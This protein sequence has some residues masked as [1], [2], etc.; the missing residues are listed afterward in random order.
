M[1][2]LINLKLS[3]AFRRRRRRRHPNRV[4]IL[5]VV[6]VLSR[7]FRRPHPRCREENTPVSTPS[8]GDTET[9][10]RFDGAAAA[11]DPSTL[12]TSN[13]SS[14]SFSSALTAFTS[15]IELYNFSLADIDI[16]LRIFQHL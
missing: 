1:L 9:F 3:D 13:P 7:W 2:T 16:L 8:E 15:S 6:V 14:A 11:D 12:I 4:P 10:L 5:V